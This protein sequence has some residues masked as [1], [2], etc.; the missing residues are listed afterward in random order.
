[1]K[2]QLEL[3]QQLRQIEAINQSL[4]KRR[5]SMLF[6][7]DSQYWQILEYLAV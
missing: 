5:D 4:D 7:E 2:K 1:M 6:D 3:E